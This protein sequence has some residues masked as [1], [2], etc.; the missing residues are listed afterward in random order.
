[1][2]SIRRIKI[3]ATYIADKKTLDKMLKVAAQNA[4]LI[5]VPGTYR[6]QIVLRSDITLE[7]CIGI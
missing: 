1:M 7:G 2:D 5:L 4:T 6:K 3:L